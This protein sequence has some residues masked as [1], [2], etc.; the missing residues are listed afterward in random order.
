MPKSI[1]VLV[2]LTLL[3]LVA[4]QSTAEE[5]VKAKIALRSARAVGHV[6][7]VEVELQVSGDVIRPGQKDEKPERIALGVRCRREYEEK[8]LEVP[9]AEK[10]RL[11]AVRSYSTAT[12][13]RK[14]GDG[15]HTLGL[16]PERR[17][18]GVE[19]DSPKMTSFSPVGPLTLDELELIEAVGNSLPL[20]AVL[21][22]EE[23]AVG[24]SWPAPDALLAELLDLEEITSNKAE[25]TLKEATADVA[26]LTLSGKVTGTRYGTTSRLELEAKCRMDRKAQRIDWFA[27]RV[28]QTRDVGIVEAGIDVSVMVQIRIVPNTPSERLSEA[29]L[30]NFPLSPTE[31]LCKLIYE[32][33]K[34]G[35]RMLHDR[36]WFFVEERGE[37]VEFHRMVQGQDLALCKITSMGKI[38]PAKMPPL[39]KFQENVR[40][41]LGENFGEMVEATEP[42]HD[43]SYRFYRVVAK[44][45][46]GE[47]PVRWFYYLVTDETGRQAAFAIRVEE[48]RL[49]AFGKAG[50]QLAGALRFVEEKG[51]GKKD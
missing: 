21:P 6:D 24:Q 20:D 14:E 18:I 30:K 35:W 46:D 13:T 7:Q 48:S 11:R 44:G 39:K 17:M 47:V 2:F 31:P 4:I 5:G 3:L 27:M 16:R 43:A 26:R 32:P 29:A 40:K 10:R 22:S 42:P 19:I 28:K 1:Q 9:S 38:D 41:V 37:M 50:D 45:K 12:A 25:I 36:Q 15:T 34:G 51:Q 33:G 8:T 49:E 23:V